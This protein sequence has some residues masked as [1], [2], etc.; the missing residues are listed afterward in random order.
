MD[1]AWIK[2]SLSVL[3]AV[4]I[5]LLMAVVM[6]MP[7]SA[8]GNP[9][10]ITFGSQSNTN[11]YM[12]FEDLTEEGDWLFVAE[13]YIHYVAPPTD[14]YASQAFSFQI[15]DTDGTTVLFSTPILEY[16]NYPTSIYLT[17]AQAAGLVWQDNYAV[18]LTGN[19]AIFGAPVE[20]VNMRT[21]TLQASDYITDSPAGTAEAALRL[22]AIHIMQD[23]EDEVAL[24]AEVYV[25]TVQGVDYLTTDGGTIFLRAVQGANVWIPNL[26]Q[27]TSAVIEEE[28][29][30]PTETYA[31]SLTVRNQLGQVIADGVTNFGVWF[32]MSSTMAGIVILLLMMLAIGGYTYVK[33]QSPL[34]PDAILIALPILG[35]YLGLVP[36]AIAF[37]I[38]IGIIVISGYY[39][40]TRGAL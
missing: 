10:T 15:L 24:P 38:T 16:E 5:M 8:I 33:F 6:A 31:A 32:G 17:A 3:T 13:S 18:R 22:F 36:L 21:H 11:M 14:Y 39:F 29:L 25:A 7:V 30:D 2:G 26:L 19:P 37:S 27:T 23:I 20:G 4:T 28:A 1:K 40:F 12:V 34:V 9:N 35:A